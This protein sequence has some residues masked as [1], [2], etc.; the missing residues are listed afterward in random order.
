MRQERKSVNLYAGLSPCCS[1]QTPAVPAAQRTKP[2]LAGSHIEISVRTGG[3]AF[4]LSHSGRGL[5][6][7]IGAKRQMPRGLGMESPMRDRDRWDVPGIALGTVSVEV[8][9]ACEPRP[10]RSGSTVHCSC[11]VTPGCATIASLMRRKILRTRFCPCRR[12][13]HWRNAQG[14]KLWSTPTCHSGTPAGCP[15]AGAA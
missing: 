1:Y 9:R 7:A 8:G 4:T 12:R 13:S 15:S 2:S 14:G 10:P 11:T 6:H 5:S 3:Q